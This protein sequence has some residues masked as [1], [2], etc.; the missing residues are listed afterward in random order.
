[1]KKMGEEKYRK[2]FQGFEWPWYMPEKEEYEKLAEN[3]GFSML[4]VTEEHADRYFSD[5]EEMIRWIDQP[6]LVPFIK[7]VPEALKEEY[8][9]EVMEEML[10]KTLQPDR[11]CFETFRRIRVWAVK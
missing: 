11:T 5:A 3:I 2:S 10:K 1:K 6:S 9:N 4:S 7:C 8:R